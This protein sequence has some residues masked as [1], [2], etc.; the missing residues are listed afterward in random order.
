MKTPHK[1]PSY[2]IAELLNQSIGER[3]FEFYHFEYFVNHIDHLKRPH[4]HDHFALFFVT[5]GHGNHVIDFQDYD[6]KPKRVFLIAPGQV[7]AWKSFTGVH[8]FALLFT[9][10]F[11]TLTLQYRE[12]RSY[13]F[14]NIAHQH[15]YLDLDNETSAHLVAIF[16]GIEQEYKHL[17]KYSE[18]I[19][20]SYI[21]IIL[22]ELSRAYEKSIPLTNTSDVIFMK[23]REFEISVNKNFKTMRSVAQYAAQLHITPNYLNSICQKR[24]G[25]PAGEIIRDRIMLEARRL[26]THSENSISQIAYDLNFEDNSYFGRFFKKYSGYSPAQFRIEVKKDTLGIKSAHLSK[27]GRISQ[28]K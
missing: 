24:K 7:H 1:I 11:F 14:S 2:K 8:G 16:N 15:T 19:I 26:L 25:K 23:M 10:E 9:R 5:G 21:N 13:L 4:R 28:K 3:D 17:K 27:S 6:L 12:L 18:H 20:R 22:F